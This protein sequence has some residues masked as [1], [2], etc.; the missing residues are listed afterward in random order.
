MG[1]GTFVAPPKLERNLQDLKSLTA[2]VAESG[3]LLTNR[4]ISSRI[5]ECNKQITLKLKLPLGSKVME[6][7]R[8]R[9][10]NDTPA[11]IETCYLDQVRFKGLEKY[12]F[13]KNSLYD[14][15]ENGY[16]VTMVS[17]SEKIGITYATEEEAKLLN[18]RTGQSVFFL[19]AVVNDQQDIPVEYTKSVVR[20]DLIR[21]ASELVR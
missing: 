7:V 16:G 6:L 18:V 17:G 21:F 8:L 13:N 12:D 1:S 10:F 14:I 15:L 19:T 20:S 2:F 11:T 9:L 4:V 5:M 3:M